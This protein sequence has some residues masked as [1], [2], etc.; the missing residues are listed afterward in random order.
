MNTQHLGLTLNAARTTYPRDPLASD[1]ETEKVLGRGCSRR[2]PTDIRYFA[3]RPL[4][5]D[6]L[7]FKGAEVQRAE[8]FHGA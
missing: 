1:G 2:L 8:P 4:W 7:T 3:T 6:D 5:F